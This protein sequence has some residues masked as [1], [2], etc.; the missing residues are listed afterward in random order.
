MNKIINLAK[1]FPELNLSLDSLTNYSICEKHYNQ[2]IARDSFINQLKKANNLDSEESERKRVKLSDNNNSELQTFCD[3]GVQVSLP[4][5][6]FEVQ[7]SLPDP[8]YENLLNQINELKHL[9][10]QLL[11]DNKKLLFEKKQLLS[12]NKILKKKL[13]SRFDNQQDHVEVIINIVKKERDDLYSNITNLIKD[14][15]RFQLD[16]L[17]E[18]SSS[19]WLIKQNPVIVNFIKMLT[20]NE[21]ENQYDSEKLF[22]CVIVVD[23]IYRIRH[24]KYVSA[25][26]L[27]ASAIKYFIARSKLIIDIDNHFMNSGGYTKFIK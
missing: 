17:L 4:V 19:Q 1:Y 8:E 14:H 23:I 25:I 10:K 15:E 20:Y 24:L 11:S 5:C 12:E 13:N 22:K 27:V 9:N 18:Y 26:N 3:F 16:S 2:I 7:V 6:D 21:N